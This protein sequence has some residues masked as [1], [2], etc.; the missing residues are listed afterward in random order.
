[1]VTVS[2][3][4]GGAITDVTVDPNN[5]T[6]LKARPG[7]VAFVNNADGVKVSVGSK[8]QTQSISARGG[9]IADFSNASGGGWSGDVFGDGSAWTV[10]FVVGGTDAAPTITIGAVTGGTF[11]VIP[12]TVESGAHHDGNSV[13][14]KA[15]VTFTN[16]DATLTRTLSVRVSVE[17]GG[18]ADHDSDTKSPSAS[19]RMSLGRIHGLPQSVAQATAGPHTW[20]GLLC[21][22]STA[23]VK[24]SV[25]ADGSLTVAAADVTPSTATVKVNGK[26]AFVRFAKHQGIVIHAKVDD[27]GMITVNVAERIRCTDAAAP[28][29]NGQP[30][31]V[32]TVPKPAGPP[33]TTGHHAGQH[34]H[35]GKH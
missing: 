25:A 7:K 21:D 23:I 22:N 35:R 31:T 3:G 10:P 24:Y 11:A 20:T 5:I 30:T 16:A 6:Q 9:S 32:T 13:T 34:G 29:I 4:A 12:T 8:G 33:N 18:D 17:A 15:G 27:A 14:A 2:T 1:V 19:L 28:T 26:T